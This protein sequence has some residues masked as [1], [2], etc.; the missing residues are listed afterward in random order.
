MTTA[1][2]DRLYLS[3]VAVGAG[4]TEVDVT[5]ESAG[6]GYS[7]LR[8]IT[9]APGSSETMQTGPDEVIVVPLSGAALVAVDED[10]SELAGRASV[11]AGPTD[12]AYV[13]RNTTMAIGSVAGGRFAFCGART[14][15]DL[16]L[17]YGAAPTCR[18]SCAGPV[19]AHVR[20]ATSALRRHWRP[21]RSSR[22]R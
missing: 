16:P 7:S 21:V 18:W 11:F 9:L 5:P 1:D 10:H 2:Q 22:V 3:A 20:S 15:V 4:G 6:W 19:S 12:L 17:R 14:E 13:P 8:V